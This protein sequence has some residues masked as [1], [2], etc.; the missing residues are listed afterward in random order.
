MRFLAAMVLVLVT[1]T[2]APAAEKDPAFLLQ[3]MTHPDQR[4]RESA[5][6]QLHNV[7]SRAAP[8]LTRAVA[9]APIS[10]AGPAGC[11]L[12]NFE[13]KDLGAA[14]PALLRTVQQQAYGNDPLRFYVASYTLARVAPELLPQ[15]IDAYLAALNSHS[16]IKQYAAVQALYDMPNQAVARRATSSLTALAARRDLQFRGLKM[17][18]AMY[19]PAW[20][21]EI[22]REPGFTA[23]I[24]A[25]TLPIRLIEKQEKARRE[26]EATIAKA[27]GVKPRPL[28][29][30]EDESRF[31]NLRTAY[32]IEPLFILATLIKIEAPHSNIEPQ[33]H[34]LLHSDKHEVRRQ[35]AALL[36]QLKPLHRQPLV[37]GLL[38][39]L[40]FTTPEDKLWAIEALGETGPQAASANGALVKL[41]TD[42]DP[43]VR[44]AAA[45]SLGKINGAHPQIAARVA[46]AIRFHDLSGGDMK[47]MQQALNVL[48]GKAPVTKP[49][50]PQPVQGEKIETPG[51]AAPATPQKTP[52]QK[53]PE[54]APPE[55][56][57][58]SSPTQPSL[59]K[60][61][62][63]IGVP[64]IE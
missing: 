25:F 37:N 24:G 60:Q 26:K 31:L 63:A 9:T 41:L 45:T 39:L 59:P 14:G 7:A 44:E 13:E 40:R 53:T 28:P 11:V 17:N 8:V 27:L 23:E 20:T 48:Q 32:I 52:P 29:P 35:A 64:P 16:G 62:P 5:R 51:P 36:L 2:I 19:G 55:M 33:L 4:I 57:P 10:T 56:A 1:G 42:E 61:P 43:F 18:I 22:Q 15:A 12:I 49:K 46:T 6:D 30:L 58:A 34:A 21:G 38:S 54:M 47:T 50:Q 3:A